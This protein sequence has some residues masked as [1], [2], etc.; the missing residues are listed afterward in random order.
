MQNN[1][2][3]QNSPYWNSLVSAIIEHEIIVNDSQ[4]HRMKSVTSYDFQS[5]RVTVKLCRFCKSKRITA[6]YDCIDVDIV[7]Y[8][9]H[10][11]S[12]LWPFHII[13]CSHN[14]QEFHSVLSSHHHP[15][16]ILRFDNEMGSACQF[17]HRIV[18]QHK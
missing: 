10:L 2:R 14:D 8:Q 16:P 3:M 15:N 12:S 6:R 11:G 9:P 4:V 18:N 17:L 5:S 7:S 13:E 1:I